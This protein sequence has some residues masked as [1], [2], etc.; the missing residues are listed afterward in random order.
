MDRDYVSEKDV[1]KCQFYVRYIEQVNNVKIKIKTGFNWNDKSGNVDE[2]CYWINNVLNSS[3]RG[4]ERDI[5]E[6]VKR[7]ESFCKDEILPL[8]EFDWIKN[9]KRICLWLWHQTIRYSYRRGDAFPE[10]RG[11]FEAL[12]EYFDSLNESGN[13]K[14]ELLNNFRGDWQR[15]RNT[16]DPFVSESADVIN[17]LWRY[18][19]KLHDNIT[20][21]FSPI[22]DEDRKICLTGFYDCILDTPEKKEL[23]LRK[24][25]SALSSHKH[26]KKA[27]KGNINKNFLLSLNNNEKL[28]EMIMFAGIKR[29]DFMNRLIAEEYERH[30]SKS[31]QF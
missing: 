24:I 2:T 29:D 19:I 18:S 31:G 3:F 9:N 30:K 27:G 7:M 26:R 13:R 22:S 20:R 12:V 17:Y 23:F 16:F 1:R 21:H 11:R 5:D 10:H 28:N 25:K 14:R 6:F 4:D 8:T 15:K